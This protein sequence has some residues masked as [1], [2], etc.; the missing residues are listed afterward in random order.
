MKNKRIEEDI[1]A[2]HYIESATHDMS[3]RTN[4]SLKFHKASYLLEMVYRLLSN[5]KC[6]ILCYVLY[7]LVIV[8][9]YITV[10]NK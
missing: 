8:W 2:F 5:M 1:I 3:M 6:Y 10:L 4:S 7:R 9:D